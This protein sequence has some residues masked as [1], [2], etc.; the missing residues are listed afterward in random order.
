MTQYKKKKNNI[1]NN[2]LSKY[3]T[4]QPRVCVRNLSSHGVSLFGRFGW[5]LPQNGTRIYLIF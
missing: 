5:N 4:I 2:L 3:L 1:N